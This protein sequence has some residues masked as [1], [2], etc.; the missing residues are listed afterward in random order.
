MLHQ[1]RHHPQDQVKMPVLKGK[2]KCTARSRGPLPVKI[3]LRRIMVGRIRL[4]FQ[5]VHPLK[6]IEPDHLLGLQVV[7]VPSS[8]FETHPVAFP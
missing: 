5:K 4:E 3:R 1:V 6:L 2:A 8:I 7:D